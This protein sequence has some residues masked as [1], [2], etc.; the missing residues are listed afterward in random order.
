MQV[1]TRIIQTIRTMRVI[2][3]E[4]SVLLAYSNNLSQILGFM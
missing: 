2:Q 4:Y 3:V 1:S